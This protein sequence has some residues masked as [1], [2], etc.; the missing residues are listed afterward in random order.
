MIVIVMGVSGVGKTT[1]GSELARRMG[2]SFIEGD[3]Y[4]PPANVRKMDQGIPLDD[5][6]R[7]PWLRKLSDVIDKLCREGRDAVLAVSALKERHRRELRDHHAEVRFVYLKGSHPVIARRMEQRTDHFMDA[8]MLASQ[9]RALEEPRDA[10][11]VDV[12]RPPEEIVTI[13]RKKLKL[14]PVEIRNDGTT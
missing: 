3:D 6:D 11:C 13:I 8:E 2:W 9:F 14:K 1:V 12:D 5:R 4:H 7:E 10:T